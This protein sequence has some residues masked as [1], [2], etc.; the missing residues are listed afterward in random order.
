MVS[1]PTSWLELAKLSP[2]VF[3]IAVLTWLLTKAEQRTDTLRDTLGKSLDG[4]VVVLTA[5]K[6]VLET[7]VEIGRDN[8]RKIDGLENKVDT[9]RTARVA[10]GP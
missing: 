8:G 3:T 6:T 10:R 7:C 1:E 9:I 2:L 5:L 4:A